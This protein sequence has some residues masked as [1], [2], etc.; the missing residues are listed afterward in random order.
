LKLFVHNPLH[1][2]TH[3]GHVSRMNVQLIADKRVKRVPDDRA[4]SALL[5]ITPHIVRV[6]G[7]ERSLDCR[8]SAK[9]RSQ[10]LEQESP[11]LRRL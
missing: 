7:R 2:R 6:R 11:D 9:G 10:H 4:H 5:L 3:S 1:L 8:R